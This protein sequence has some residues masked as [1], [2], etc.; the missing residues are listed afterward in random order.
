MKRFLFVF[1]IFALLTGCASSN[2]LG[3]SDEQWKSITPEERQALLLKQQQ[4]EEEQRTIRMKA[5]AEERKIQLKQEMAERERLERL[6][7]APKNGNVMMINILGGKY[8]Y[9]KREKRILEESY[10]IARGETKKIQLTLEN[11]K[12]RY[13]STETAYLQYSMNGNGIY[14]YLDN[15]KYN[16]SKRIALLRDGNWLC[17]TRYK[18]SLNTS[19][20]SLHKISF[21]VKE[22]GSRCNLQRRHY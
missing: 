4:Y 3:M 8:K 16:S 5:E 14:L 10:E 1:V 13:N 21:F 9:G 18:K 15:P 17:G 20:E 19:Y 22:V 6:Y 2:P 11:P 12:S 7:N